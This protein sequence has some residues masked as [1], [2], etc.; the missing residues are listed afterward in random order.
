M[1]PDDRACLALDL[2][3]ATT[4]ASLLAR[5][6][7]RWRL[8]GSAAFP[9][10]IPTPA[11]VGVLTGRLRAADPELAADLGADDALERWPRLEARTSPLPRIA[12][13]AGSDR[14]LEQLLQAAR[15]A[16]WQV[17]GA[18][19]TRADPLAMS[20]LLLRRDVD[21]VLAGA[22][23]PPGGDERGVLD[24]IAGLVA[25]AAERR[26]ELIVVLAGA[27]ADRA[28][29]FEARPADAEPLDAAGAPAAG[30]DE[31]GEPGAAPDAAVAAG[32][33]TGG[34][35]LERG[36]RSDGESGPATPSGPIAATTLLLA[37]SPSVGDPP[38]E[39]LRALLDDL[40]TVPAD[41]RRAMV[42]AVADLAGA[43]E[44]RVELVGVGHDGGVR[45]VA[46]PVGAGPTVRSAWAISSL[47]ALIPDPIDEAIVDGVDRWIPLALDRYRLRDRLA[48]L[49]ASPWSDLH[50][51]G[52]RLRLAAARA[53]VGRMVAL[54]PELDRPTPELVIATGGVW[55]IAPGPVVALAL[56][57]VLRRPGTTQLAVDAARMLAPIGTI[58]DPVLRREVIADL[59]DDLVV[60]LG[61]LVMPAGVRPGRT[62]GRLVVQG[63][64]GQTELDL[65]PG[66]LELVDLPPGE[67]AVVDLWF[68]DRVAIGGARGR[69]FALEVGGGLSGMLVDLR[70]VPLRLPD[71]SER[72]RELLDA[73]QRALW[74]GYDG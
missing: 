35:A 32:T 68:R 71:R 6:D 19:A 73:W 30:P 66:G 45:A 20:H 42:R 52:A 17:I 21:A 29:R 26:P 33:G 1:R 54:S 37:P 58:G 15:R 31:S 2:G 40:R 48:D 18:S 12:V 39:P 3:G 38:G 50:G 49:R 69:R 67:T 5:V 72:R 25:A 11:I 59:A 14:V 56:A 9:S 61:A 36:G 24:D 10:S 74:A 28:D 65:V 13:L 16:G 57:D 70:D 8:L 22:G 41:G 55:S 4:A 62:A 34:D 7:G 47:G 46:E 44:R 43:L 64:T 51:D 53:A 23:D 27:L 60:P 63:P